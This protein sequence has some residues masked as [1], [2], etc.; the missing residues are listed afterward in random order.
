MI[1]YLL[2]NNQKIFRWTTQHIEIVFVTLV[3]SLIITSIIIV[4]TSLFPKFKPVIKGVF[5]MFYA[6]LSLA[7]FA[8]MFT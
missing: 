8:L 2:K 5:S 1:D 6:I 7:F 4:I 3:F